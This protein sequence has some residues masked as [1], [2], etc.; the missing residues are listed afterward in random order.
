MEIALITP[1]V[2]LIP[3]A[4]APWEADAGPTE[5]AEIARTADRLGFAYL[6]CSE[7]VAITPAAQPYGGRFYDPLA[8]F[9]F[10]AAHTSRIR[11]LTYALGLGYH[12]PL[13]IAKR[14]GTLDT[15][16]GGR[17]VLG[18]G[19]GDARAQFDLLGVPYERRGA[20]ADD[21]L[22]ALRAA[23]GTRGPVSYA[24]DHFAFDGVVVD[25]SG[26]QRHL[27]M[28]IGGGTQRSLD[29]AVTLGD[30]WM[31]SFRLPADRVAQMLATLDRPEGFTVALP[32]LPVVD[33]SRDPSGTRAALEE[34][35]RLGADVV[36][37]GFPHTSLGHYL[38]QLDALSRVA[39][40]MMALVN[41]RALQR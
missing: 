20:R 10:L 29:R 1:I 7:H 6:T 11:F 8:T 41:D 5:L 33:P 9:G 14:Y 36:L 32:M 3:R 19:L 12:H 40:D 30:G 31:P 24:G 38:E 35:A 17:V 2:S 22:R 15:I 25:P 21:A 27:P 4:H 34:R 37:V 16:S 28:W 13:A 18:V 23:L 26:V 39:P